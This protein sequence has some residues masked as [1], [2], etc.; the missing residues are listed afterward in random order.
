M[1]D[2]L[3]KLVGTSLTETEAAADIHLKASTEAA[4]SRALRKLSPG[5]EGWITYAT[6]GV[7]SRT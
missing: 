4:L 3:K 2:W 7:L 6:Y 5:Q 1:W